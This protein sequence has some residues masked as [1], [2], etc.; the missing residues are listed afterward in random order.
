SSS[1]SSPSPPLPLSL[2]L[3]PSPLLFLSSSWFL[4]LSSSSSLSSLSLSLS[5]SLS[6]SPSCVCLSCLSHTCIGAVYWKSL[7]VIPLCSEGLYG[8]L[9]WINTFV[10]TLLFGQYSVAIFPVLSSIFTS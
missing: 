6:S 5:L 9:R 8:G 3:S 2:F 4:S 1:S 7:G 10:E